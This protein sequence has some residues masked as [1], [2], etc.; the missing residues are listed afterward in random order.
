MT[1]LPSTQ[2]KRLLNDFG[3]NV[4][5]AIKCVNYILA[6]NPHSNPLNSNRESTFGH[7][8]QVLNELKKVKPV[9]IRCGSKLHPESIGGYCSEDCMN[10]SVFPNS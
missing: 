4:N 6:S 5:H 1:D 7:W 8:A 9:C 2:A 3:G 10:G